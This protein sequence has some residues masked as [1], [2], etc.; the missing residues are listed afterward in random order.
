V[1]VR[2]CA[3]GRVNLLGE[4]V[5]YNGGFVL[6]A[7]IDRFLTLTAWPGNHD[8]ITLRAL[9][10]HQ[11][12][13][14]HTNHLHLK[15]TIDGDPLPG[16]ALYPA[17]VCWSLQQHGYDPVPVIAEYSSTIPVGAGL[18]S[19]AAVETAF[20]LLWQHLGGWEMDR[21]QLARICLAAE[22][23][24]VG[25]DCGI[26]DQFACLHGVARQALFLDTR[27]LEWQV[28]P[29]PE[30]ALVVANT[31]IPHQLGNSLS[32]PYNTRR[33]E[34]RQAL[35]TLQQ[36]LPGIH[37]LRDVTPAGLERYADALPVVLQMRARH[38]VEECERVLKA[39]F[40]LK[41]GDMVH[42]GALMLA[43]H[44]SL[45][46]LFDVS[47]RELDVL[48]DTAASLP[49]CWGTRLN[50]AGFGGCTI[51]LVEPSQADRFMQRLG[52][53]YRQKTGL[54]AEIFAVNAV[55]VAWVDGQPARI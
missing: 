30:A 49:G 26:M 46:D 28:V 14:I 24:Y 3:P 11:E 17:G 25:V 18:S 35:Q 44:A 39:V 53:D 6:P 7:A 34:C 27:A 54:S 19:S 45:R 5:D 51:S 38:V 16:W 32:S 33:Q 15:Q 55:R 37:D 36:Y 2:I 9:D 42:F 50:G 48:V 20:G 12:V 43:S 21:M 23:D 47:S 4:H 10:L 31:G 1:S 40:A 22:V 8:L 13:S 29:L 41:R 52:Q